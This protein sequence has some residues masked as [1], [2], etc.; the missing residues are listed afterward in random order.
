MGDQEI[1]TPQG[2]ESSEAAIEP[3][4][5]FQHASTLFRP[6]WTPR[7]SIIGRLRAHL[8]STPDFWHWLALLVS[9]G[10]T[11][12][13]IVIL[14]VRATGRFPSTPDYLTILGTDEHTR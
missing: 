7:S 4:Q 10:A 6:Q 9:V 5:P 14:G 2:A 11:K 13:L 3:F 1:F 8:A 12:S